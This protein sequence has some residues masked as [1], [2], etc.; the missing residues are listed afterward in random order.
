[1]TLQ[2]DVEN[3]IPTCLICAGRDSKRVID[4]PCFF[5]GVSMSCTEPGLIGH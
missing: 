1:M 5:N 4:T 2:V 3:N